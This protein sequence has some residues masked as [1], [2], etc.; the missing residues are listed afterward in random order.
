MYVCV[1]GDSGWIPPPTSSFYPTY[2]KEDDDKNIWL[3]D[4]N[5]DPT[6]HNDLSD[7]YPSVVKELLDKL[8]AYNKTAVPCRFPEDDPR[9]DP[10][11][12]GG[13]WVP[14]L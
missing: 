8:A 9:A 3:F 5:A 2:I 11:L 12:H 4:I 10:R 7:K 14:W 13:A 1:S 6:E